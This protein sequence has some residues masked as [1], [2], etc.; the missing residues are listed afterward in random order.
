MQDFDIMVRAVT[1]FDQYLE[2]DASVGGERGRKDLKKRIADFA[3][4]E[5]ERERKSIADWIRKNYEVIGQQPADDTAQMIEEGAH[6][7]EGE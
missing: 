2:Y 3:Y 7:E 4:R 6:H 5:V 1:A